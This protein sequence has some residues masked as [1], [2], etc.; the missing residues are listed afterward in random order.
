MRGGS[1]SWSRSREDTLGALRLAGP[2]TLEQLSERTGLHVNTLRDHLGALVEAGTVEVTTLARAGRGRPPKVYTVVGEAPATEAEDALP[3]VRAA[4]MDLILGGYGRSNR[5]L[6]ADAIEDG[7]RLAHSLG[8]TAPTGASTASAT[9]TP[10]G[11]GP[12]RRAAPEQEANP[13]QEADPEP[14]ANP[15]QCSA[16]DRGDRAAPPDATTSQARAEAQL[17]ALT[18]ALTRIGFRPA[19]VRHSE[20]PPA[21]SP[22]SSGATTSTTGTRLDIDLCHCPFRDLAMQRPEVV[23]AMHLGLAREIT[24]SVGGPLRPESLS[25][26]VAPRTCT[27]HLSR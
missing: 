2:S 26:F 11:A 10:P 7:R 16:P 23:C 27:L 13:E 5:D 1:R 8:L 4:V 12:D 20:N 25:P 18:N 6:E 3:R 17:R 15:E 19:P 22:R 9:S 14:V 24:E 21:S